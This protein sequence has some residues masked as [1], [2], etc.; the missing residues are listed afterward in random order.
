M[1]ALLGV[2]VFLPALWAGFVHDDASQ[3][4]RNPLLR[5]PGRIPEL[6]RTGVWAGAG[7]GSS[8]YRPLMMTSFALE[9]AAF[10]F[11]PGAMHGVQLLFYAAVVALAVV[12]APVRAGRLGCAALGGALFAVHPLNA[13]AAVWLSARNDLLAAFFGL[14]ALAAHRRAE[15]G[16]AAGWRLAAG[17]SLALALFSKEH[18]AVF[19]LVLLLD[20]WQRR[21]SFSPAALARRFAA[22]LLG[23]GLYVAA[24]RAVLGSVTAELVPPLSL[25]ALLGALGQ[26][27]QRLVWPVGLSLAPPEPGT[28]AVLVGALVGLGGLA[29]LAW[30]LARRSRFGLPLG[31]GLA[32][33]AVA[34]LAAVRLGE[35]ADRYLL[36]VVLAAAWAVSLGLERLGR[37]ALRRATVVVAVAGVALSAAAWRQARVFHS[38]LTLWEHAHRQNPASERAA[39]NLA[40]AHLDAGRP[41]AALAL[42]DGAQALRPDDP[43]VALN[44]GV[45]YEALGDTAAARRAFERVLLLRPGDALAHTYLGHLAVAKGRF[46]EADAHYAAAVAS[47]PLSAEAWAGLALTCHHRGRPGEA[48]AALERALHLDPDVQNAGRL[49]RLIG[50]GSEAP[51]P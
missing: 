48:R 18:A 8:W 50:I 30:A 13:E 42:L 14:L 25:P 31:L 39:L 6:W 1:P 47:R 34:A 9:H 22:P 44:R 37:P 29:G 5:D 23:C 36:L 10:G 49:R 17:G 3:I 38:N 21:A 20:D 24:R 19:L 2:A 28:G 32:A 43:L 4:L 26:G 40:T 45:A 12:L 35:L 11:R 51:S 27:A 46:D 33:A 41:D 15:G 7:A 16:R